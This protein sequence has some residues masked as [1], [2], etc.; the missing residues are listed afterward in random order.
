MGR[1]HPIDAEL[2]NDMSLLSS[3]ALAF[4]QSDQKMLI[5]SEL[6]VA[7]SGKSFDVLD[8]TSGSVIA[9]VP[10]GDSADIDKAVIAA[11]DAFDNGEWSKMKPASRERLVFKLADL[12][13]KN[14]LKV[15][16]KT[17]HVDKVVL[18]INK[19]SN[20]DLENKL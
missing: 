17:T 9:R 13:E 1:S 20:Q 10:E 2:K 5:G 7:Q 6:T 11:R 14:A 12:I 4:I 18:L 15:Y 8:P 19:T 16:K 3:D